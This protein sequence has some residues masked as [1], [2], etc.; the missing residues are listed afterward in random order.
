MEIII[1]SKTSLTSIR[2]IKKGKKIFEHNVWKKEHCI[3]WITITER[4]TN[5]ILKNNR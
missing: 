2:T 3:A 1:T 4:L 5:A